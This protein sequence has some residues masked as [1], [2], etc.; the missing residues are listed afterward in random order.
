MPIDIARDPNAWI[1]L[2]DSDCGFCRWSLGGVL[3]LD[4]DTRLAP[5]ALGTPDADTLLADLP[6]ERRAASWHL[7]SPDGRRWSAGA[8]A[9][10]LLRLLR[11]GR[12]PAAALARAPQLTERGYR[13]VANHRSTFGRF[14]SERAKARADDRIARAQVLQRAAVR[15]A[16][17][18]DQAA[19]QDASSAGSLAAR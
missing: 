5:L 8:G 1:I 6:P 17:G 9:P 13:W 15:S 10:P 3:A 14:V 12:V 2:Y 16:Q 19:R 7:V 4:R 11:G 18:P